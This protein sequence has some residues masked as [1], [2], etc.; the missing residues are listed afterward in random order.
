MSAKSI[1]LEQSFGPRVQSQL[2]HSEAVSVHSSRKPL[3][4][5]L[6][7]LKTSR[8]SPDY[9]YDEVS[10]DRDKERAL[11]LSLPSQVTDVLVLDLNFGLA[12]AK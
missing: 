12:R 2:P 11:S 8:C 6:S 10:G 1:R 5:T 3:V 4:A 9:L 7:F